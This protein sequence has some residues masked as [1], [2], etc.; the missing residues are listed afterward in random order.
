[1]LKIR[2]IAAIDGPSDGSPCRRRISAAFGV[3]RGHLELD[4]AE[5]IAEEPIH[6]ERLDI[7]QER[8]YAFRLEAQAGGLRGGAKRI[9]RDG[10]G[11][12]A[13]MK[14]PSVARLE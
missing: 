7:G 13:V 12:S 1:M 5:G 6:V 10:D 11:S 9:L 8:R 2:A 4:P 3:G 14:I